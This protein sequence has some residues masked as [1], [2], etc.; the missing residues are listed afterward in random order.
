MHTSV[1]LQLKN[2]KQSPL[3]HFYRV[4]ISWFGDVNYSS[5]FIQYNPYKVCLV[6]IWF[7]VHEQLFVIAD[8]RIFR[9]IRMH[10]II[11]IVYTS[12]KHDHRWTRIYPDLLLL[13][14]ASPCK[15]VSSQVICWIIPF[16]N[17]LAVPVTLKREI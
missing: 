7:I 13:M 16:P 6:R 17:E 1:E 9:T 3:K 11:T 2:G 4:C 12:I 15:E 10:C 8:P 5:I 14:N